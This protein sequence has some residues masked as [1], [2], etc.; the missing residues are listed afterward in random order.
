M[1]DLSMHLQY[2]PD[3]IDYFKLDDVIANNKT[4]TRR[5]DLLSPPAVVPS[6]EV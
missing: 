3:S 1:S 4:A 2:W 6:P 5:A